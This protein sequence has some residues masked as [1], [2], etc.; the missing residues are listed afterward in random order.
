MCDAHD[1][2]AAVGV[3]VDTQGSSLRENETHISFHARV[4]YRACVSERILLSLRWQSE[5]MVVFLGFLMS[6]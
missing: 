4:E 3:D 1:E 5:E 2:W 6:L